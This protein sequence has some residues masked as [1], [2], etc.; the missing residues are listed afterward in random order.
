MKDKNSTKDTYYCASGIKNKRKN[1]NIGTAALSV[2]FMSNPA[3]P[4][5]EIKNCQNNI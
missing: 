1:M 2:L 3:K 4:P 5:E